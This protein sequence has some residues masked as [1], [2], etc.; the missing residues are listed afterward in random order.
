MDAYPD[1]ML[2]AIVER[3]GIAEEYAAATATARAAL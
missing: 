2:E 1:E 3:I